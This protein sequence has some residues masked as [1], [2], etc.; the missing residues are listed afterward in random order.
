MDIISSLI[1]ENY[2][3]SKIKQISYLDLILIEKIKLLKKN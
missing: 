1:I 2:E 3:F